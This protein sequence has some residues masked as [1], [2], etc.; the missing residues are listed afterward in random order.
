MND[1]LFS[2]LTA[3][4]I[5]DIIRKE[6]ESYFQNR[7]L[8]QDDKMLSIEEACEYLKLKKPTIYTLHCREE[9]PAHKRGKRLF[10]SIKDLNAWLQKPTHVRK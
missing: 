10:F 9:I 7:E 5:R 3:D 2:A 6:L 8:Q 4:Q 1:I